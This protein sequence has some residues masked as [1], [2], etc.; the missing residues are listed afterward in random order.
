MNYDKQEINNMM[1]CPNC[2]A[3][4]YRNLEKCPYCEIMNP[5]SAEH[6]YMEI[7]KATHDNLDHIDEEAANEFQTQLKKYIFLGIGI[8]VYI[9]AVM[10]IT[11][12]I[13]INMD[14]TVKVRNENKK[15]T[16]I[17]EEID[18]AVA[19]RKK[20]AELDKLYVEKKYDE[21]V[22]C[23]M[24]GGYSA[25]SSRNYE[26]YTLCRYL[27]YYRTA[28]L[29]FSD[30]DDIESVRTST[31]SVLLTHLLKFYYRTYTQESDYLSEED[32]AILDTY[33]ETCCRFLNDTMKLDND[34]LDE[35]ERQGIVRE[36]GYLRDDLFDELIDETGKRLGLE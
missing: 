29:Y 14:F 26:H 19:T 21:M 5:E 13:A 34:L 6:E 16:A 18:K 9:V 36:Y 15:R 11:R 28:K 35:M 7:L 20:I 32:M 23:Y 2:G 30:F 10:L 17:M 31:I 24:D 22:E 8:A 3:L 12:L 4:I 27:M 25:L 1:R 33:R